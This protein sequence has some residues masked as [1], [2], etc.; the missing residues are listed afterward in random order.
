M[1][2]AALKRRASKS[3]LLALV[4]FPIDC[5]AQTSQ[6]FQQLSQSADRAREQ[7]RDDDAIQLYGRA[8][9]LKP[10]SQESLWYG[11]PLRQ[12]LHQLKRH[13]PQGRERLRHVGGRL[14]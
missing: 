9:A 13:M 4:L 2:R 1:T 10:D 11:G 8:L 3:L 5:P 12:W 6:T 7:S 14:T